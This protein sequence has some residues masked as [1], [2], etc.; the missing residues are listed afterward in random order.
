M[1]HPEARQIQALMERYDKTLEARQWVPTSE[2]A[3]AVYEGLTE[4]HFATR[5]S[6]LVALREQQSDPNGWRLLTDAIAFL[7]GRVAAQ[8]GQWRAEMSAEIGATTETEL[9][10]DTKGWRL[11]EVS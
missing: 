7:D 1:E 11:R 10:L 4:Q 5:R 6:E 2:E 9:G 3:M 8:V